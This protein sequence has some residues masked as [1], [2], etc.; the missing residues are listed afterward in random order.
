MVPRLIFR[1]IVVQTHCLF[2]LSV[3]TFRTGLTV[4]W[5]RLFLEWVISYHW[6]AIKLNI[7]L[8]WDSLKHSFLAKLS[9]NNLSSKYSFKLRN[10]ACQSIASFRDVID[11]GARVSWW[12]TCHC[13]RI[14]DP[15]TLRSAS[16][17]WTKVHSLTR[18]QRRWHLHR[19]DVV[20]ILHNIL[21]SLSYHYDIVFVSIQLRFHLTT[22]FIT[23]VDFSSRRGRRPVA[24]LHLASSRSKTTG[25]KLMNRSLTSS[26]CN[27]ILFHERSVGGQ[28]LLIFFVKLRS[29]KLK[30]NSWDN[31]FKS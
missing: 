30:M 18:W 3:T 12:R 20:P 10:V 26:G 15:S 7:A 23:F 27:R 4:E 14:H 28:T 29:N 11:D 9:N 2:K 21:T 6:Y 22:N 19:Y 13:V 25:K 5:T 17:W 8:Y 31:K 1:F 24:A 16:N